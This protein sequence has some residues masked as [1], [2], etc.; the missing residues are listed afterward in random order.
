MIPYSED[1]YKLLHDGVV[2]LAQVEENG[3]AIDEDY[4]N[5]AILETNHRIKTATKKMANSEVS[6]I[7]R[8]RFKDRTNFGSREQLGKILF[9]DMGFKCS[10]VTGTGRYTTDG[11]E[12]LKIDH[13]FVHRFLK[14][15]KM[16]KGRDKLKEIQREVVD[17]LCHG[18]FNLHIAQTYRSSCDNPNLQNIPVRDPWMKELVRK[19]IVPRKPGNRIV[20]LDYKGVEVYGA[21]FYHDDPNM[22][23]YLIDPTKDMHRDMAMTCFMLDEKDVTQDSRYTAKNMFVFPEF[24]GSWWLDCSQNMWNAIDKMKL[25]RATDQVSL[26]KHLR[27]KGIEE[28]GSATHE[29]P[30][31]S[32]GSFQE[33]LQKVERHFW[34][35]RFP[36]Y[37]QWKKDWYDDYLERGYILTKTGFICHGPMKR[38]EVINYPVQG[39]AFHILLWSMIR[40][41]EECSRLGMEALIIGQVHD[42]IIADVPDNEVEDFL[43]LA[44]HIMSVEVRK[45]WDWISIPLKI[46]PGVAPVG[47]SWYEKEDWKS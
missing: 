19:A 43:N 33:H 34:Q 25:V 41:Q 13:P 4:L 16:K 42:S 38:T 24:Y 5:N 29:N 45:H 20:E 30:S 10:S 44:R 36:T 46:D 7:W 8:R 2:A 14:V 1:A 32:D 40:L 22:K 6:D 27:K 18:V 17:G 12:L 31:P 28:L 37:A 47:A 39:I 21:Y 23:K 3:M 26:H 11:E 35:K 9:E 15:E